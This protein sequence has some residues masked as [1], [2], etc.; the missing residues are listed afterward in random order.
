MSAPGPQ[1]QETTTGRAVDAAG[2]D[3]WHGLIPALRLRGMAAQLA[4][5]AVVAAWD[6]RRL[7]LHVDPSCSS[8]IGSVAEQKLKAAVEGYVSHPLTLHLAVGQAGVETPAQRSNRERQE[9]QAATE[10]EFSRDPLVLAAQETFD[11][12]IIP[13][14]IRRLD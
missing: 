10:A 9:Q 1:V 8:L 14:S 7:E 4:R 6:G 3:D 13:D 12:E 5:N 2:F 11:A